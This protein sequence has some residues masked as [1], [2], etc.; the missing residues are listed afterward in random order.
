MA[1][2]NVD[3]KNISEPTYKQQQKNSQRDKAQA[4]FLSKFFKIPLEEALDR[5]KETADHVTAQQKLTLKQRAEAEKAVATDL[6]MKLAAAGTEMKANLA[7][8]GKNI[9]KSV[10]QAAQ[11]A[12][13]SV[14]DAANFYAEYASTINARLQGS[15]KTFDQINKT[16]SN[17]LGASQF[18]NQKDILKNLADLVKQ[19]INYNVEQRAFLK[20][21]S[22]DI[23]STFDAANGTLLRIVRIQQ[24]DSTVARLGMEASLT[25]YF[26]NRYQDSSYLSSTADA[27][28]GALLDLSSQLGTA[29]AVE[30]EYV[31]QK[32]LGSLGSV[33]VADSTLTSIASA[34]NMLGT[35][36]VSAL[37]SNQAM[38]NLLVFGA[39]RAG[40]DYGKMLNQGIDAKSANTLL[41]GI[42][43]FLLDTV[44]G[45]ESQV[46]KSEYSKLFG[47]GLSDFAA[48][49][50]LNQNDLANISSNMLGYQGA[51]DETSR[52][53]TL[54][55][56]RM[57]IAERIK[58]LTE[59]ALWGIGSNIAGNP[60]AYA[61]WMITDFIE[62][63]TGGIN[64]PT[65]GVMGSFV[66][67]NATVTQLMKLGMVGLSTLNEL[68]SIFQGLSGATPS[69]TGWGESQY[70]SRGSGFAGITVGSLATTSQ[71]A[72]IGGADGQFMTEATLNQAKQEAKEVAVAEEEKEPLEDVIR[73]NIAGTLESI[74]QVLND[75]IGT[76]GY[77]HSKYMIAS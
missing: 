5:V 49:L 34:L 38:Q 59:N 68:G 60:A 15:N 31:V 11:A 54:L 24:E 53:L 61:T 17:T 42:V 55:P 67:M 77:I 10:M 75:S 46:L 47:I 14:E 22:E 12:S 30:F 70:T 26:N 50:N 23:A 28:S 4:E 35:G 13:R 45:A 76:A 62:K 58:N 20:T 29:G 37:S 18:V 51:I 44:S 19:G 6:K 33:G 27:V 72:I 66:D 41:S 63:M 57:H 69:L 52:Q 2:I 36:Q 1:D 56:S 71:S 25:Q 43:S 3:I 64:I 8:A 21:I 73:E 32:W 40:L 7:E 48:I 39:N 65:V 74:L 9:A 16:I